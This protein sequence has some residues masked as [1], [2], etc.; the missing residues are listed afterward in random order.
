M[1]TLPLTL[2]L[3]ATLAVAGAYGQRELNPNAPAPPTTSI[4]TGTTRDGFYVRD[5]HGQTEVFMV[6][7]GKTTLVAQEI[8]FP[9]GIRVLP[10]ANITLRDGRESTLLPNQWLDFDGRI[11]DNYIAAAPSPNSKVARE[12][13]ISSRDGI[14][15]SGHDVFITRN[16][17]ATKVIAETRLE[18]GIMVRP[19]G[20]IRLANGHSIV[21]RPD[22]VLDFKGVIHEAPV[23]P[24]PAGVA[25]SSNPPR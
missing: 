11:D 20:T 22:Q 1:K 15:V 23:V 6:R 8:D 5:N 7:N 2:L 21:L 25:P 17:V 24:S 3:G 18:S 10:N 14:T 19:D 16:G 12:S 13:G 4:P 9:N